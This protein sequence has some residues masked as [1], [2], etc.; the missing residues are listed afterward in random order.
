[1]LVGAATQLYDCLLSR[2]LCNN[3]VV[4]LRLFGAS[5]PK[6][7]VLIRTLEMNTKDVSSIGSFRLL[8]FSRDLEVDGNQLEPSRLRR[9]S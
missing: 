3:L 6:C 5:G 9:L 1:M 4:G 2:E 8:N 7:D